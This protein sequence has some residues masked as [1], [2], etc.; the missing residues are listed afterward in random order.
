MKNIK[1]IFAAL[2]Y[3]AALSC[4]KESLP[5]STPETGSEENLVPLVLSTGV[6]TKTSLQTDGSI[7][8][9]EGD[10][11][12]VIDNGIA[13]GDTKIHEFSISN[14]KGSSATFS[15]NV[16]KSTTQ[17]CAVYPSSLLVSGQVASQYTGLGSNR[18]I[19]VRIP[20]EQT[21]KPGTFN[22]NLNIS[23]AKASVS[24]VNGSEL[25]S[26][27][28]IKF[29]NVCALLSFTM[30]ASLPG[31][32]EEVTISSSVNIA[33]KM[34]I[35]YSGDTPMFDG[36]SEAVTHV[37]MVG[38]FAANQ[39]YYFVLAP[40]ELDG[41]SINVTDSE[42]NVYRK[43]KAGE[44]QLNQGTYRS[45]G[46][47]NF[48][49][50]QAITISPEHTYGE[51]DVLT[52]TKLTVALPH[53]DITD[54]DL[55]VKN[56]A[57]AE[58]RKITDASSFTNGVIANVKTDPTDWPYLPKGEYTL[59]GSY[60]SLVKGNIDVLDNKF[61]VSETPRP[62]TVTYCY[63]Y[64]SYT[65]KKNTLDGSTIYFR[66]KVDVSEEILTN[67]NYTGLFK[68][69]L[70]ESPASAAALE[71]GM[72]V[73]SLANQAWKAHTITSITCSFD[74]SSSGS[75]YNPKVVVHV[76]GIPYDYSFTNKSLD[77]IKNDSWTP[78]GDA[79]I[80]DLSVLGASLY[81]GLFLSSRAKEGG[82]LGIGAK[83]VAKNGYMVSLPFYIPETIN[84]QASVRT[85]GYV[86]VGDTRTVTGYL[87]AVATAKEKCGTATAFSTT[88]TMY[89]STGDSGYYSIQ[90]QPSKNR[91]CIASEQV[92][93][94]N[95]NIYHFLNEAH[96]RYAE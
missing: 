51:S 78:N 6:D 4:Q 7:Y 93:D 10:Q 8:W 94:N 39:T 26:T 82:F 65:E 23:V 33:G 37:S 46:T 76:T 85:T 29:K 30:P 62:R 58:V 52:G 86:S 27:T 70:N 1:Y 74:G 92:T 19:T 22:D 17:I 21:A 12:S 40:V 67:A 63:P 57:G 80:F 25:P 90:F 18:D 95:G 16:R 15:G 24:Y 69:N 5:Q 45:L 64:T 42:G 35:D 11:I 38:D 84:L 77:V 53:A 3:L 32:I 88:C 61:T 9:S 36:L 48:D 75:I 13:G 34:D 71:E 54:V 66:F 72:L 47:L 73:S 20:S 87:G 83:W 49:K 68:S 81:K 96:L 56:A 91:L 41:I 50:M 28:S 31:T 60:T 79:N 2:V 44:I 43:S 14:I 89:T 55:I 59:S